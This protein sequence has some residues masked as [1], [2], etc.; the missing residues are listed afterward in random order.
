M[1][2][3]G[4][5]GR[6]RAQKG[7][8]LIARDAYGDNRMAYPFF[9]NLDFTEYKAIVLRAGAQDQNNGKFRDE[10]A[11]GLLVGSD[12]N[13]L[14]QAYKPCVLYLNGKYWGHYNMRE[15]VNKWSVAQWE[16]VTDE[17]VIDNIDLLKG[18]G[19]SAARTLNGSNKEYRELIDFCKNNSLKSAENLK[20]VT[21]RVDVQNYLSLIHI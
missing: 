4:S 2:I 5:F 9:E 20:Y 13:F 14:Y 7:F 8:N 6:G 15:R 11:T 21:D 10:L 3:A 19:N 12:V 1:R 18:N 16:G 17:E